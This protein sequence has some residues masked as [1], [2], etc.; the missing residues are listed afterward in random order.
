MLP[1]FVNSA[2]TD[3]SDWLRIAAV[4]ISVVV[5]VL[6]SIESFLRPGERWVQFRQ[7]AELL[8][9]EWWMYVSLAGEYAAFG[10]L[11]EGHTRFVERVES[12]VSSDVA[13][14]V[15]IVNSSTAPPAP[16]NASP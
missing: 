1:V 10:T 7:T 6:V 4:T 12:I 5:G 11:A 8:R 3:S 9:S 13:G 14:F 15:A 16:E 2:S